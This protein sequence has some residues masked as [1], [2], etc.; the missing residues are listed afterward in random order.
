MTPFFMVEFPCLQRPAKAADAR[1]E[2]HE[3]EAAVRATSCGLGQRT[4]RH[5]VIEIYLHIV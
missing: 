2:L 4:S 1:E 5:F 3:A